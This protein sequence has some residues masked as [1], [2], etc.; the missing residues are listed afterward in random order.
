MQ[1]G[2]EFA[3]GSRWHR[4]RLGSGP[5]QDYKFIGLMPSL[6]CL[7][8]SLPTYVGSLSPPG[9]SQLKS[10]SASP[11]FHSLQFPH[12]Q[13]MWAGWGSRA[14]AESLGSCHFALPSH[15]CCVLAVFLIL[16]KPSAAPGQLLAGKRAG[17]SAF[18]THE[19]VQRLIPIWLVL[20]WGGFCHF[21]CNCFAV[22]HL[23][24]FTP[25]L[26]YQRTAFL[27]LL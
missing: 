15:I 10:P 21:I 24:G 2:A 6:F 22:K 27:L 26:F 3:C 1:H 25:R 18:S 7:K 12:L 17:E 5:Q 13:W 9:S 14:C 16:K 8:P 11:L 23:E 19:L 20:S 4:T